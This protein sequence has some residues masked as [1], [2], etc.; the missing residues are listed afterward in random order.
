MRQSRDDN[1]KQPTYRK[2][3]MYRLWEAGVRFVIARKKGFQT[4]RPVPLLVKT[5]VLIA[6]IAAWLTAQ[7]HGWIDTPRL[8]ENLK[9][10]G[11]QWLPIVTIAIMIPLYTFALPAAPLMA[12]C[13]ALF[14]PMQATV[15]VFIGGVTGSIFAYFI[16]HHLAQSGIREQNTKPGLVQRMRDH[17]TF[18]SLFALR[19]CPGVPHAAINYTAGALQIPLHLFIGSTAAGFVAKGVVYTTAVHRAMHLDEKANIWSWYTL[20]PLIALLALALAGIWIERHVTRRK[21]ANP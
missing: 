5:L 11:S 6:L 2:Y 1:Q 8:L 13:G 17:T 18:S 16:S 10:D 15:V 7:H 3:G 9:A 14:H 4:N 12:M 20:W 19:I 21:Q